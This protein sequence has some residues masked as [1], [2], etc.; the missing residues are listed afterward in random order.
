[1]YLE[2]YLMPCGKYTTDFTQFLRK[3]RDGKSLPP[4]G[5]RRDIGS[6]GSYERFDPQ[7]SVTYN[8]KSAP[9]SGRF[10]RIKI[11]A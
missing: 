11:K 10:Q 7:P 8:K 6:K 4:M 9:N 5:N 2:T 1:M 3:H